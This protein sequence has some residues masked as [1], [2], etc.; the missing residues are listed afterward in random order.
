MAAN[1]SG[2]TE[3]A[4]HQLNRGVA[5]GLEKGGARPY[6][7]QEVAPWLSG[8]ALMLAGSTAGMRS[9]VLPRQTVFNKQMPLFKETNLSAINANQL[10]IKLE[11]SNYRSARNVSGEIFNS[12]NL[13]NHELFLRGTQK[14]AGY[15][16]NEVGSHLI[17]LRFNSFDEFRQV[18][19]K[20][21]GESKYASEFSHANI[22]R[23]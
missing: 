6:D 12:Q 8:G 16:P 22:K 10:I 23:M 4:F 7:A 18:F 2:L 14:N 1:H 9:S 15:I 5:W 11:S 3:Q 17:G 21:V 19:W 13:G 20:T